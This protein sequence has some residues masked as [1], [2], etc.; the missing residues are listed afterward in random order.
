M[1]KTSKKNKTKKEYI[2]IRNPDQDVV[3]NVIHKIQNNNGYCPC[4]FERT[5]ETKCRCKEFKETGNCICGLYVKIP[6]EEAGDQ[7]GVDG[8]IWLEDV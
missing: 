7:Q 2:V 4:R 3:N 6:K 8:K 1:K 5:L